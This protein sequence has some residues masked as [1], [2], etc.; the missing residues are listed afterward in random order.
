MGNFLHFFMFQK[1]MANL[2]WTRSRM[3]SCPRPTMISSAKE[4]GAPGPHALIEGDN[5]SDRHIISPR[6]LEIQ[7]KDCILCTGVF[8][9]QEIKLYLSWLPT[10]RPNPLSSS[11]AACLQ[12]KHLLWEKERQHYHPSMSISNGRM[13]ME[14]D[15]Q[16]LLIGPVCCISGWTKCCCWLLWAGG[17]PRPACPFSS[18][19]GTLSTWL[20]TNC[21]PTTISNSLITH[22]S[23]HFLSPSNTVRLQHFLWQGH[24]GGLSAHGCFPE[25]SAFIW[26]GIAQPSLL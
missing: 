22:N 25:L 1:L 16:G 17:S 13:E 21:P 20:S 2:L 10:Q 12:H 18:G 5:M 19:P 26:S 3:S 9:G 24:Y 6:K 7:I 8:T 14:T 4:K 11:T 15:V 23:A